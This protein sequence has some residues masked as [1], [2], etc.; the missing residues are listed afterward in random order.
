MTI[1]QVIEQLSEARDVLGGE[2]DVRAAF[3]P[4]WPMRGTISYVTVA[5]S[6]DPYGDGETAPGQENDTKMVWLAL[7]SVDYGENP[8]GPRW[9]WQGGEAS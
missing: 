2:A 3:Q 5:N 8:Y 4:S 1:D 6:D 7:G 9:A